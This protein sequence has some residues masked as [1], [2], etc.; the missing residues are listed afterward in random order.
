MSKIQIFCL[1]RKKPI[2]VDKRL[3]EALVKMKRAEYI[4][5]V[6]TVYPNKM[7]VADVKISDNEIDEPKTRRGRKKKETIETVETEK[8]IIQD[9]ENVEE[10]QTVVE[11]N[12]LTSISD[13]E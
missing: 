6:E 9:E 10:V 13:T 11:Q 8:E 4:T 12:F 2:K 1:I 5:A 7:L 3:G